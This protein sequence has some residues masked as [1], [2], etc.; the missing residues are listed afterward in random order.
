MKPKSNLDR[1]K[2]AI[3]NAFAQDG[4][5][6]RQIAAK[7]KIPK[8][9]VH[10]TITRYKETHFN[11]DKPRSGRP[12]ITSEAENK[13]IILLSKRERRKTAPE[14]QAD[15]NSGH[16]TNV[17]VNTVKRRLPDVGLY[18]RVAKKKP[19]LRKVNKTKRLQ[20][21]KQ[22]KNWSVEDFKKVL[23]TDESKFEIFGNKR[24]SYVRRF[25]HEKS[26]P[27]CISPTVKHGGGSIMV[28]GA[29]SFNGV[30]RL[31]RIDEILD[32]KGYHQIL[33]HQAVPAGKELIGPGFIMPQD[34]DPKNSSKLCK[35][36]L[37]NKQKDRTLKIMEWPAQSP[38]LNPIELVWDELDR[39]VRKQCLSSK[40]T[41]WIALEKTWEQLEP[42]VLEKLV[43][44]MPRIV[45]KVLKAKGG[46]FDEK[47]V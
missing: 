31:H 4:L 29:F 45:A 16:G 19:L 1:K 7:L 22:H 33:I 38:D 41:L 25:A 27:N 35:T 24:R 9:T 6:V 2:R 10:D 23:W 30:S 44:R 42:T 13:S 40:E 18:G 26:M 47:E 28:W 39:Q 34:N 8:S 17:S 21:A 14:I 11:C 32:A 12:R 5:S 3:V 37:Q 15:F 36:Y 43:N 20:W 46:Y